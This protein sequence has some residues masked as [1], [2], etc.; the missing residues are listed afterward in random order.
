MSQPLKV[1]FGVMLTAGVLINATADNLAQIYQQ[2]LT[3]DP[4]YQKAH[5]DWLTA[6]ELLPLAET[7][8]GTAGSG[9]FPNID[10]SAGATHT[11]LSNS[12]GYDRV[13]GVNITQPIFNLATWKSIESAAYSVKAATATYVSSTQAL[14]NQVAVAYFEVLRA[15]EKLQLTLAEKKQFL[16]EY[17]IAKQKFDVGLI[18]I[19][20]VYDAQSKYDESVAEE[21]TDRN[22]LENA[23]G[24]LT[25][26]T[27]KEYQSVYELKKVIPLIVPKPEKK[28]AWVEIANKQNY[29]IQ[30]DLNNMLATKQNV[31]VAR[32]AKLPTLNATGAYSN[33][34]TDIN[35]ADPEYAQLGLSLNFPILR[36]GYDIVN[37]RQ[38][39][40]QY[41]AASDQLA[42]DHRTV[43][44][45]T[46]QAYLGITS[47]IGKIK[48]SQQSI[49][50]AEAQLEATQAEYDAGTRTMTDLLDS[51][52][53]LTSAKQKYADNRYDYI[54]SIFNLKLQAGTLSPQD[55]K[56]IN[57]WL[58]SKIKV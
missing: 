12:D 38:A 37:T 25:A 54:E 7:G 26:I 36:G 50:S 30:A 3:G 6:K 55:I 41:L 52:T 17:K 46:G 28:S 51:I 40:Y 8:N 11:Y 2:A 1:L 13:Y 53:N 56:Q 33:G 15:N 35:D 32:Y 43:I 4:A 21:I 18:A 16:S 10:F 48:A 9:L 44:N 22:Q 49:K 58:G 42:L 34:S 23:L 27:G 19:A 20:S 24:D 39:R 47:G 31:S 29:T 5:A 57:S 45:N 14:I